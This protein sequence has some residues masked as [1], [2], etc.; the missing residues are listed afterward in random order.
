MNTTEA[1]KAGIEYGFLD[2]SI[3]ADGHFKPTLLV[4]DPDRGEKVLTSI[5]NELATCDEFFFS[6]AFITEG[7][8]ETILQLS[9]IHI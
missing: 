7:G 9:L 2:S 8:V 4:N 3:I 1:L 5:I 6:V